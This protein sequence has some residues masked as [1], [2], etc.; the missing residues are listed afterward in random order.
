VQADSSVM[1]AQRHGRQHCWPNGP[2]GGTGALKM[3]TTLTGTRLH[4]AMVRLHNWCTAQ[5]RPV[6]TPAAQERWQYVQNGQLPRGGSRGIQPRGLKHSYGNTW[7]PSH[8]LCMRPLTA[9]ACQ[10]HHATGGKLYT[11]TSCVKEGYAVRGR[12]L[13]M[14]AGALHHSGGDRGR[15]DAAL[16]RSMIVGMSYSRLYPQMHPN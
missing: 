9:L 6:Q 3:H 16:A 1:Q 5:Q 13:M 4:A 7:R 2:A 12:P 14:D 11:Y 15:A 8:T 10:G